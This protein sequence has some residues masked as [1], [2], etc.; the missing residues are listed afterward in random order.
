[1]ILGQPLNNSFNR[2]TLN[3]YDKKIEKEFLADYGDKS[4][5]IVQAGLVLGAVIFIRAAFIWIIN[6]SQSI[7]K[8]FY[9]G[10]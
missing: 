4:A 6:S 9:P 5:K 2:L 10:E 8:Y 1:M 3:F 7:R